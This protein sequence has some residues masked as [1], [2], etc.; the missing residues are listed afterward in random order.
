M[1]EEEQKEDLSPEFSPM[2]L[3]GGPGGGGKALR[4]GEF[5][6]DSEDQ[7]ETPQENSA[8]L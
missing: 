2:H 1:A 4:F 7:S 3:P 8:H 6:E 5:R